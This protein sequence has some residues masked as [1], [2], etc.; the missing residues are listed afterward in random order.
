MRKSNFLSENR[1]QQLTAKRFAENSFQCSL[2]TT[3]LKSYLV[4]TRV[5][6]K[7]SVELWKLFHSHWFC[8]IPGQEIAQGIIIKV[9]V[10]FEQT[11]MRTAPFLSYCFW[12]QSSG[13]SSTSN[14]NKDCFTNSKIFSFLAAGSP[15]QADLFYYYLFWLTKR[16]HFSRV[17]KFLQLI[18]SRYG[19]WN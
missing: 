16:K 6:S 2:F 4:S 1:L 8:I 3:L 5:I 7:I 9:I 10:H 12:L 14:A 13:D 17:F 11:N 18:S 15:L 19:L